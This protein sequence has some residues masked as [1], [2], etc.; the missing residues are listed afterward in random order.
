MNTVESESDSSQ[1]YSFFSH[2]RFKSSDIPGI[3][4]KGVADFCTVYVISKGKISSVRNASRPAPHTSPLLSHI[5]NKVN[6]NKNNAIASQFEAKSTHSISMRGLFSQLYDVSYFT[7]VDVL[8]YP[9]SVV[10]GVGDEFIS[11]RESLIS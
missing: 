1:L 2:R 9:T 8:G 11:V 5:Q 4:S 7:M 6:D 10:E 3:V